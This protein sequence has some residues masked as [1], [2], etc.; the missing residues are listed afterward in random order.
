MRLLSIILGLCLS[1]VAFADTEP[2]KTFTLNTNAF[3]NQGILPVL[4]TCDGKDV[5]PQLDWV[6]APEKTQALALILSDTNAPGG[7][8]YH[9]VVYNIPK[10]VTSLPQGTKNAPAG[11]LA[12]KNSW[13]KAQ[14]NG[15]CPPK[16]SAHI[17]LF[18]LYALDNK[19]TLPVGAD[20]KT[21]LNA[22]KNHIVG[23]A[24]ISAVYSRWIR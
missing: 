2:A 18:T 8:F 1:T 10:T 3:L 21:L 4:Y 12:G 7:T 24:E 22:M 11:S 14:Y 19:L 16:G 20:A 13:D 9:W 5:S 15:P 17:Y 23:K 6:D